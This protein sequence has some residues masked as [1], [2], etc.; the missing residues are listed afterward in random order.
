MDYEKSISKLLELEI[1]PDNALDLIYLSK[2]KNEMIIN[3]LIAAGCANEDLLMLCDVVE[4]LIETPALTVVVEEFR[5]GKT[6]IIIY[7]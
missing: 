5:Q 2:N 6:V 1:L 3:I 4:K 7:M